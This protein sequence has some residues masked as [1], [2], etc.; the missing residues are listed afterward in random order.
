MTSL[1]LKIKKRNKIK[2]K[3]LLVPIFLKKKIPIKV[4]I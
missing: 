4:E 1:C 3:Q 2:I